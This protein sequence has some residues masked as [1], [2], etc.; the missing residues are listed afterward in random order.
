MPWGRMDDKW[1]KR[2]DVSALRRSG[3]GGLAALGLWNLFVSW[4][5]DDPALDGFVPAAELARHERAAA[6]KLVDAQLWAVVDGGYQI[7][8][9][10]KIAPNPEQVD[11]KREADRVRIAAKRA[12]SVVALVPDV[13]RDSHARRIHARD[14]VPGPIPTRPDP[15]P[16]LFPAARA[17]GLAKAGEE[18]EPDHR[19]QP[20]LRPG[21]QTPEDGPGSLDALRATCEAVEAEQG[22]QRA[23]ARAAWAGLALGDDLGPPQDDDLTGGTDPGEEG[24]TT[25]ARD[26]LLGE[27]DG[28]EDLRHEFGRRVYQRFIGLYQGSFKEYPSMGGKNVDGFPERLRTTAR[29]REVDPFELLDRCFEVFAREPLDA[30]GQRA[31][32]A[33]FVARF[34]NYLSKPGAGTLGPKDQLRQQMKDALARSDRD[35][36]DALDLQYR[37]QY[38]GGRDARPAQ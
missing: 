3:P 37:Q 34:G 8:D 9:F 36:Y 27:R 28:D 23:A 35:L 19:Q 32:Y 7:V 5:L 38:L 22:R 12:G 13:A 1:W 31:P 4:C 17:P 11:A 24:D 33:T 29:L 10:P 21:R 30:I 20:L 18:P 14:P 25:A 6:Q 16:A 2:R 26:A 15:D